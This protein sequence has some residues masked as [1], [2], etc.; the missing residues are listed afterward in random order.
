MF[1][2]TSVVPPSIELARL[3]RNAFCSVSKPIACSGRII[4]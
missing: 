4:S 3:R 1:F 2:M